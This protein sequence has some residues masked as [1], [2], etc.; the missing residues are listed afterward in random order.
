ME[1]ELLCT[2]SLLGRPEGKTGISEEY[3]LRMLG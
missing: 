3:T 2:V 1:Q